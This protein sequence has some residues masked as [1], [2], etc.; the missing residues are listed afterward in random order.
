MIALKPLTCPTPR[1]TVPASTT[2]TPENILQNFVPDASAKS[3]AFVAELK[4]IIISSF[5]KMLTLVLR[6]TAPPTDDITPSLAGSVPLNDAPFKFKKLGE[7][8]TTPE[9]MYIF[10]ASRV[11][12]F[13]TGVGKSVSDE[14]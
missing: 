11:M 12:P 3:N 8:F 2:E 4:G 10:V 13:P 14:T 5:I 7:I 1:L 9:K 6:N